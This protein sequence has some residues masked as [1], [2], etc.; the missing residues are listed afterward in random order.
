MVESANPLLDF[1]VLGSL[2]G[3]SGH[4]SVLL[5]FSRLKV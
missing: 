1:I 3:L 2:G 4:F 5:I